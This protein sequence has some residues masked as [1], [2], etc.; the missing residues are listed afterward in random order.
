MLLLLGLHARVYS[1]I[2]AS[3]SSNE[4][5]CSYLTMSLQH[6]RDKLILTNCPISVPNSQAGQTLS[7]AGSVHLARINSTLLIF[8]R[9]HTLQTTGVETPGQI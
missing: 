6:E 1:T 4:C 5:S 9:G 7:P 3:D 2:I 8:R